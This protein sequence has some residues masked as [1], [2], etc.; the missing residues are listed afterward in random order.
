MRDMKAQS[1]VTI[2]MF[3]VSFFNCKC[4]CLKRSFHINIFKKIIIHVAIDFIENYI[5]IM[6]DS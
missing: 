5:E 3:I 4:I 6:H 2:W 1:R